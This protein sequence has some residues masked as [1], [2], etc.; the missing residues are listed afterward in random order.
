MYLEV[1]FVMGMWLLLDRSASRVTRIATFVALTVIAAGI[2]ATFT[3][4]GLLAMAAALAT[5]PLLSVPRAP[6][7]HA[8][9]GILSALATTVIAVTFV[10]HSPE[11]W[12]ARMTTEGSGAWY[13]ATYS[14]PKTLRLQTGAVHRIPV[15]LTNTGRLT[16]DSASDPGF[17][18]SYH[19]LHG[20]AVVVFEGQR[21]AF[22]LPIRPGQRASIAA[23][24]ITPG[25]P[26]QYTLVWDIVHETR[27]W[28]ST[29]GVAVA[30]TEVM[31]SGTRTGSVGTQMPE[32]PR[33]T[34]RPARP[35]L[36]AAAVR[37]AGEHPLLGVGPDNYRFAY[38]AYIGDARADR[39]VHANNMY[40]EILAG[41]GV[42]G[43][44]ALLALIVTAAVMLWRRLH[45]AGGETRVAAAVAIA[46]WVVIAGHGLVDSFLG[47]TTTYVTF[48]LACALTVSPGFAAGVADA[49]R[50]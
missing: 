27:A 30:R 48:A 39:R 42:L 5:V 8:Q 9:L 47:F 2:N 13:G 19:W 23:A 3:R 46:L 40:L 37:M 45:A 4:A 24:V 17:A 15:V 1:A 41:A 16:W 21:T 33:A 43:L 7:E 12:A 11:R 14:V 22:P 32:L 50:V 18:L 38:G 10:A 29:E 28:L 25:E 35:V 34:I 31:V 44:S 6:R 36:W 49:H 20:D 26:G